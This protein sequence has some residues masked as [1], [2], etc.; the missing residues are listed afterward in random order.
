[1]GRRLALLIATYEFQDGGLQQLTAPAHDA[2]AFGAVLRDPAIAGFEVTTLLN[3]PHHDVG[4]AIADFYR[5]RHA[6]DLILLYF[7]GHGIKDGDGRLHLAMAD[8]SRNAL[9]DTALSAEQINRAMARCASWRKVLILDCCYSG[10]FPD[11]WTP[12]ADTTVHTLERFQGRGRTVLTASDATQ[13]SWEGN[14]VH[15]EAAQSVFTRYL[16][17][18]LREGSA[19]LDGDGDITLD[20]LYNYVHDHVVEEMP[21][22]RPKK[23]DNVEGR[24]VIARNVNWTLP[25]HLRHALD[26]PHSTDRLGALDGLTR[27]HGVG[28]ALVR[29]TVFEELQRLAD[30][31]NE[32][33][34]TAAAERLRALQSGSPDPAPEQL[35]TLPA[36]PPVRRLQA[37]ASVPP[38]ATRFVPR[39][40]RA[41][42]I[43]AGTTA[44][45]VAAAVVVLQIG[46]GLLHGAPGRSA[47]SSSTGTLLEQ[48][49]AVLT[50]RPGKGV[51]GSVDDLAFSPDGTSLAAVGAGDP[52]VR[53]WDLKTRRP[54]T[55]L[56][57]TSD[58]ISSVAFSRDGTTLA[59]GAS[60]GFGSAPT[61]QVWRLPAGKSLATM[62]GTAQGRFSVALSPDGRI[63][64][65]GGSDGTLRLWN[66]A[67]GKA[68]P[69]LTTLQGNWWSRCFCDVAFSPDGRTL[70]AG[71]SDKAIQMWDVANR[72][73]RYSWEGHTQKVSTVA[74]SGD[75]HK[76]ASGSPDGTVRLWDL[77]AGK[78]LFTVH[79]PTG[80]T[81]VSVTGVAFN[82]KDSNVLASVD[83][84][85]KVMLWNLTTRKTISIR[86]AN[87]TGL[88][89]VAWSA[90][91]RTLATGDEKDAKVRLWDIAHS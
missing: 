26:S 17:Q 59:V 49:A 69:T 52:A 77:V 76:L 66:T 35:R 54:L 1:M 60:K 43:T 74:F 88:F 34:S 4:V 82:P 87:H 18:G 67:T 40:R 6:D 72:K 79:D 21:H 57:T 45:V 65:T 8:T 36:P 48:P 91:G 85:G 23:Q 63:L 41:R 53:R 3:E 28:N 2:E 90:D 68:L 24:I 80:S 64:A 14:R 61:A 83:D 20:E 37:P 89:S 11:G 12:K 7:T 46:P 50:L 70:A 13:Y 56:T 86:T 9:A 84:H 39:T 62:P 10:A 42:T 31:D 44:L 78:A 15:G 81:S 38:W 71:G 25:A 58:D 51:E 19:D 32:A 22:Q 30:G 29:A 27:L 33:V 73:F 47:S 75:G 55:P 5:D 16:V